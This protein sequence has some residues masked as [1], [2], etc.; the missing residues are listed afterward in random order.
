MVDYDSYFKYGPAEGRNGALESPKF[1]PPC[2]CSDCTTNAAL[3]ERSLAWLDD[4]KTS[5][6][7]PWREEQ[8]LLCPP[9][10]LGYILDEKR[11]AQLQVSCLHGQDTMDKDEAEQFFSERLR[12][13]DDRPGLIN[14]G[15][16]R[17]KKARRG[18]CFM[19]LPIYPYTRVAPSPRP[20][21]HNTK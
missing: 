17:G 19:L 3:I 8:Y 10:V 12:L 18:E 11:W 14:S 16:K 21:R 6:A 13:A 1:D 4:P 9:R 5:K 7:K 20:F 2:T 15:G